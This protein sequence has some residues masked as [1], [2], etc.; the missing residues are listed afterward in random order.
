M[1][2]DRAWFINKQKNKI[3]AGKF[4]LLK[5]R[6]AV[7]DQTA[8]EKERNSWLLELSA[9][10]KQAKPRLSFFSF[11][12]ELNVQCFERGCNLSLPLHCCSH[13]N[14][15]FTLISFGLTCPALQE[16]KEA[17]SRSL[18][19]ARTYSLD[20]S[21]GSFEGKVPR[22]S[23][24]SSPFRQNPGEIVPPCTINPTYLL[25]LGTYPVNL[26]FREN[27]G[28]TSPRPKPRALRFKSTWSM[29]C[30]EDRS[31][32]YAVLR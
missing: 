27:L 9:K 4:R 17:F 22:C 7:W 15:L 25:G 26:D 24:H 10:S 11:S 18:A 14:V 28:K 6:S 31:R 2:S 8:A 1:E 19:H 3:N 30:Y 23:S 32:I 5:L 12:K 16:G 21:T 20:I 29:E 13:P